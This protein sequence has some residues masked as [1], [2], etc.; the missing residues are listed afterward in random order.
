MTDRA[1]DPIHAPATVSA[2][3]RTV[4]QAAAAAGLASAAPALKVRD[5]M[6]GMTDDYFVAQAKRLLLS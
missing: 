4:L 3:R 1:T 2:T 6:A 5:F